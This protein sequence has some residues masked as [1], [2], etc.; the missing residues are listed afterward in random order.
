MRARTPPT[1][2]LRPSRCHRTAPR[3]GSAGARGTS[4]RAPSR[5]RS[6]GPGPASRLRRRPT[7]WQAS[8]GPRACS[9]ASGSR[10]G[11]RRRR[12]RRHG[13]SRTAAS[14]RVPSRRRAGRSPGSS[15]RRSRS[16]GSRR[17]GLR[18]GRRRTS[19][20]SDGRTSRLR[21]SEPSR[22][23][24]AAPALAVGPPRSRA[25]FYGGA[26][27][28]Y[29]WHVTRSRLHELSEHGVSVWVDS[30]SREMLETGELK[31]LIHDDAVV[32]VTSNPT[33][34]EK[35][36]STGDWYDEQL[37]EELERTRRHARGVLRARG[38]GHQAR[39][40]SPPA[41]V[42]SDGRRRRVR[43]ARGRPR[44]GVRAGRDLRAGEAPH[45]AR[46]A[47]RTSS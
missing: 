30:L 3:R 27:R 14:T 2:S 34:F 12:H 23:G 5:R 25:P 9:S 26:S 6:G 20:K 24:T 17:R 22:R 18:A 13:R 43:L 32:G 16:G 41:R 4:R 39:V 7:G 45:R 11:L 42:G 31:R 19:R 8:D 44:S 33:I 15:A 35:A 46:R 28:G 21:S 10:A 36:L 47:A 37:R 38:R 40:R 29:R 1:W